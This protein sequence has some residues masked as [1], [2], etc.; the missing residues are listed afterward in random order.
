MPITNAN[1]SAA[2]G[3]SRT[4]VETMSS[5]MLG[6]RRCFDRVADR[7]AGDLDTIDEFLRPFWEDFVKLSVIVF[8]LRVIHEQASER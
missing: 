8:A 1:P 3:A 7:A 6:S 2:N 4:A 5:G